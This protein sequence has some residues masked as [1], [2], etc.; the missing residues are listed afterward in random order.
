MPPHY[1]EPLR[2][3]FIRSLAEEGCGPRVVPFALTTF[4]AFQVCDGR[5]YPIDK[6]W[7]SLEEALAE[8]PAERLLAHKDSLVVRE[9]GERGVRI[10]VYRVKQ[11][12]RPRYVHQN[13]VTRA[14]RD[15]YLDPVCTFDGGVFG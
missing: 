12:A 14:V 4:R 3:Q 1:S 7:T 15:L 9:E 8:A 5:T 2:Q 6:V 11:K 13:H 10:H